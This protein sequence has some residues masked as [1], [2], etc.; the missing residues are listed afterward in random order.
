MGVEREYDVGLGILFCLEA[1]RVLFLGRVF[2]IRTKPLCGEDL[3][4]PN[5]V[6]IGGGNLIVD[7]ENGFCVFLMFRLRSRYRLSC[8]YSRI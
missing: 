4:S 8:S 6:G 7:G 1:K 2:L 3:I 5:V